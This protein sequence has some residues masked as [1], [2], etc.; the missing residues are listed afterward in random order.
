MKN[1]TLH[2]HMNYSLYYFFFISL[3]LGG[4]LL[5]DWQLE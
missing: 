4:L 1:S 5:N 2:Y 3:D